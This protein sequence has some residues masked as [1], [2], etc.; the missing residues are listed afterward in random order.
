MKWFNN[1]SLT[2]LVNIIKAQLNTKAPVNHTHNQYYNI[3][4]DIAYS[5]VNSSNEGYKMN[6]GSIN[7]AVAGGKVCDFRF[8]VNITPETT[9]TVKLCTLP[10]SIN[11]F[12]F[13]A[14]NTS[15]STPI[16]VSVARNG[17]VNMSIKTA[18]AQQIIGQCT[19][20][21]R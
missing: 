17:N 7:Y 5:S 6:G 16:T 13:I 9:G 11:S 8:N 20:L 4:D 12:S 19:F 15:D 10:V 18:N 3:N 21:L 1:G 2:A 14:F